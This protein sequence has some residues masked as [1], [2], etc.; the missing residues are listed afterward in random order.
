MILPGVKSM[1]ENRHETDASQEAFH[2]DAVMEE[3]RASVREKDI[4]EVTDPFTGIPLTRNVTPEMA[5]HFTESL[6]LKD[7]IRE[8]NQDYAVSLTP[9]AGGSVLKKLI[10]KVVWKLGGILAL[11]LVKQQNRVNAEMT[12]CLNS[13]YAQLEYQKHYIGILEGELR[14]LE[15]RVKAMTDADNKE[16]GK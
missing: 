14:E 9:E 7:R 15:E 12:R 13:A 8:I 6:K 4:R 3:I 1:E 11:P 5:N 10:R 2:P 16:T